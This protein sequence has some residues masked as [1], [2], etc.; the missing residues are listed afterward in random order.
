MQSKMHTSRNPNPFG[1][2][3]AVVLLCLLCEQV[4]A[5]VAAYYVATNGMSA[6]LPQQFYRLKLP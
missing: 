6:G 1:R 2:V 4:S 3:L 5:L